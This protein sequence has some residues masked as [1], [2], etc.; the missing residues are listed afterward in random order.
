[1]ASFDVSS[2]DLWR[3][4]VFQYD[5]L[6]L[7]KEKI[8]LGLELLPYQKPKMQAMAFSG[9]LGLDA[10]GVVRVVIGDAS[11]SDL[12]P[13]RALQDTA[14]DFSDLGEP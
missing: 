5:R 10:T 12:A 13:P 8:A 3:D 2:I 14:A 9:Q 6:S 4:L 1:M 11:T 7:G